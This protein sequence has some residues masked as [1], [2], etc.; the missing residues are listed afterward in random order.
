MKNEEPLI[1][2]HS[3]HLEQQ[4]KIYIFDT[5]PS[6]NQM[7]WQLLDQGEPPGTTVIA[8]QQT[9]GR[10]QWGRQWLSN[11]GGLYLSY[12]IQPHLPISQ[13]AQLTFCSAWGIATVLRS[14]GIPVYIK[15]PNDLILAQ[16]K[17]GGILTETKIHQ[18]AINK[19]V[20]GVGLN[21]AN[22]VPETGINLQSYLEKQSSVAI[23]SLEDLTN[24][25]LKGLIT[26]YDHLCT[27]G[28]DT[29]LPA[30]Q[31]LLI[32]IG[33]QVSIDGKP[34]IITGVASTGELR[35]KLNPPPLA[36]PAGGVGGVT[37]QVPSSESEI[38]LKPGT[39]SLGYLSKE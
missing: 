36:P 1:I 29:L 2:Y 27:Q 5:L 25:T 13:S 23:S 7:L 8:K 26:G 21:W 32:N 30:Y 17:L 37:H 11:T 39:I 38:Y 31:E 12:A 20:I 16:R 9:S 19:A 35:V 24:I 15:W 4:G 33:H 34:G 10:G 6:T 14:R 22:P 3:E 28:M 18:G